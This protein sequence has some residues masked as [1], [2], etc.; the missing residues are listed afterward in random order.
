[1]PDEKVFIQPKPK[2]KFSWCQ[3]HETH[4]IENLWPAA[5]TRLCSSPYSVE[6]GVP[7]SV[8]SLTV[9]RSW[10]Q[11]FQVRSSKSAFIPPSSSIY[12][13]VYVCMCA[14]IHSFIH[15]FIHLSIHPSSQIPS[16]I[17]AFV[18]SFVHLFNHSTSIFHPFIHSTTLIQCSEYSISI[19]VFPWQHAIPD[20]ATTIAP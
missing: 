18:I 2:Q 15:S 19:W 3:N 8:T 6:M 4:W 14:F 12:S 20:I 11:P 1:M 10:M 17:Y 9:V 13:C 16:F 5:N 7:A